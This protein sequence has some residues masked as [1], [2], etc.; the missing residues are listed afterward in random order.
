MLSQS[1][2]LTLTADK[3]F[4]FIPNKRP[5]D[6]KRNNN[7]SQLTVTHPHIRRISNRPCNL[8]GARKAYSNSRNYTLSTTSCTPEALIGLGRGPR[9]STIIVSNNFINT[10]QS[11]GGDVQVIFNSIKKIVFLTF[12]STQCEFSWL[13]AI[14]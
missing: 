11:I 14:C 13:L 1:F 2:P 12:F 8:R 10:G 4:V 5:R 6:I 9:A 7:A 3:F